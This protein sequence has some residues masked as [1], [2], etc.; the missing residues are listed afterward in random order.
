MNENA[1][2]VTDLTAGYNETPVLHQ[3]TFS[4]RPGE[5]RVILGG[6]GCGKTT[7]LKNIIGLEKPYGGQVELLGRDIHLLDTDERNRHFQ[8]VGVLFQ[9]GALLGSLTVEENVALPLRLH[10][11]LPETIITEMV[12]MKLGLVNLEHAVHLFP[13]EL[14]GGMKKRAA[15]ARAMIMDPEVLF[16][17]EPSAGLDPLTGAELDALILKIRQL[18][19]MTIIVVTHELM[20]IRTIAD[21]VLML[22]HGG[23]AF[24]GPLLEAQESDNPD[25]QQF[26]LRKPPGP[27]VATGPLSDILFTKSNQSE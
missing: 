14:S 22:A 15:L 24:D 2:H 25:I 27:N 4:V 19:S 1:L 6:S 18:F 16:C 12:R 3:V 5:I 8:R 21:K 7:L 26:F 13:S 23:V 20:S 11:T 17:D 9:N 10:T